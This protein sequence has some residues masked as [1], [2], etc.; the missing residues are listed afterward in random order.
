MLCTGAAYTI[1]RFCQAM[2]KPFV[3]RA[4]TESELKQALGD[5]LP[6][7]MAATTTTLPTLPGSASSTSKCCSWKNQAA[8]PKAEFTE[9]KGFRWY[10][11]K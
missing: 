1:Q 3:V 11:Q 5:V 8:R 4:Y 9:Q 6:A 10:S 7:C 2:N